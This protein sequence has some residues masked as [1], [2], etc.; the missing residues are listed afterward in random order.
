M[1]QI[2]AVAILGVLL[3]NGCSTPQT[4]RAT[5][6]QK[7]ESEVLQTTVTNTLAEL[8]GQMKRDKSTLPPEAEKP[9]FVARHMEMMKGKY[10]S[11]FLVSPRQESTFKTGRFQDDRNSRKMEQ[12]I[13]QLSEYDVALPRVS[14]FLINK[15]RNKQLAGAQLELAVRLLAAQVD[16]MKSSTE[17]KTAPR[18]S[19]NNK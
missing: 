10:P 18:S 14:V 9:D 19:P 2:M 12:L 6:V 15:F 13:Q 16:E 3:V 11:L 1:K 8:I 4:K 17:K 7:V 5:V